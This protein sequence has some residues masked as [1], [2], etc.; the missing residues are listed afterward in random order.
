[1][2]GVD[3]DQTGL[4][5]PN[6]RTESQ[7]E[8]LWLVTPG[9]FSL[10]TPHPRIL[11]TPR[12]RSFENFFG[13]KGNKCYHFPTMFYPATDEFLSLVTLNFSTAVRS[14]FNVDNC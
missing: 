7:L 14:I 13:E 4:N 2:E 11:T 3:S 10:F 1:M 8:I 9:I 6:C 5:R 12:K